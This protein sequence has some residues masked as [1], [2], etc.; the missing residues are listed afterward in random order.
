MG[1]RHP[2]WAGTA[3]DAPRKRLDCGCPACEV[4]DEGCWGAEGM[5]SA[6]FDTSAL[7]LEESF[8]TRIVCG[9]CLGEAMGDARGVRP[10]LDG[11]GVLVSSFQL[12]CPRDDERDDSL[13]DPP[14]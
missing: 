12:P 7:G 1:K 8:R 14:T 3:L 5:H 13:P 6:T 2:G 11:R 4:C 9:D 10:G